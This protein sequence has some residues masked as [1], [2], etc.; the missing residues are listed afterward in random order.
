MAHFGVLVNNVKSWQHK[1]NLFVAENSQRKKNKIEG[2]IL[3]LYCIGCS[4][5]K[6]NFLCKLLQRLPQFLLI[7]GFGKQNTSGNV[8]IISVSLACYWQIGLKSTNHNPIAWCT[9]GWKV[10]LVAAIGGFRSDLSM[11]RNTDGN[12]GNISAGVLFS[13]VAYQRKWW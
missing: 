6:S 13:K 3:S 4:K 10:T 8:S 1:E 12:F 9:E 5:W 11:T 7:R 2:R